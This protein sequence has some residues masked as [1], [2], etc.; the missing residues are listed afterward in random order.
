MWPEADTIVPVTLV[1]SDGSCP[2]KPREVVLTSDLL[3]LGNGGT[4]PTGTF[5]GYPVSSACEQQVPTGL[6]HRLH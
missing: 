5:G 4:E 2:L 6:P 1:A 3:H